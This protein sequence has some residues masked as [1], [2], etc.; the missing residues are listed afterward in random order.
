MTEFSQSNKALTKA[1]VHT[2]LPAIMSN[3]PDDWRGTTFAN[4]NLLGRENFCAKLSD[5]MRSKGSEIS[6]ADLVGVGNA[7]DYLRVSTNI[8]TL[9]ELVLATE[10]G[11]DVSKVLSFSSTAMPILAVL[12]TT[13]LAVHFYIG[14][15]GISP[16]SPRQLDDLKLIGCE[17]KIFQEAPTASG[18]QPGCIVLSS[19]PIAQESNGH[20]VSL[21]DCPVD[22]VVQQGILYI[23]NPAKIAPPSI[24][25]VRK[26][27][28][29]PITTPMAEKRLRVLAGL[30]PSE[31]AQA[32]ADA[33]SLEEFYAHLQTLSGTA[34]NP[35]TRP[36]VFTAGLPSLSSLWLTLVSRGGADVLM[37]STA[38]GG[39]SELAD[40]YHSRSQLFCKHTFDI[41]GR[42]DILT[43]ISSALDRLANPQGEFRA[44]L[45]PTT[46]LFVEVPTNP[47]MKVPD[48][49]ALARVLTA[50]QKAAQRDRVLLLV[51]TTFA[52]GSQ[53]LKQVERACPGLDAMVFI[54]LS[55]S[56]SGGR[57]T[58]GALVADS[59]GYCCEL[60]EG[61]RATAAM[62]DTCA[63]PDQLRVLTLQHPGTEERCRLAYDVARAA[64]DALQAAVKE[65]CG[66]EFMP[67]AFVTP[68][69]AAEGFT[70]STFSF[71]L[72]PLPTPPGA[73][74]DLQAAVAAANEGLAQ[75]FVTNLVGAAH[76]HGAHFKPCVSFG[77]DNNQVYATVPATSTQ[78][79]IKAEDKAKQAVGGVQLVR[80]SFPPKCDLTA[81][82]T[83]IE[84]S[85]KACYH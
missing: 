36:V 30:P 45:L 5:L 12:L 47:D 55:K 44:G 19:L 29:T 77:Q 43:A 67:L 26:R 8:S 71:N 22:G 70:S 48:M 15:D 66:G 34:P 78:G 75:R 17:L 46:V 7:E 56:V 72:P 59:A 21:S 68:Q 38:Y 4:S 6:T 2:A 41:T 65:H 52:P 62:L 24:L 3:I 35:A 33:A 32:T 37:A 53:T 1:L 42:N 74:A 60:L 82:C 40:I 49:A 18:N 39:S 61:V 80:L 13:T 51:D 83:A 73:D 57:T 20:C 16:F 85:V 14:K 63:K 58:A 28:S 64:G 23:H 11:Y 9:L 10:W 54:S 31:L 76:G 25:R 81:V 84:E 27:M 50:Y 69:H 79:A